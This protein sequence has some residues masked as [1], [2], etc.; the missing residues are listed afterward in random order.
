VV[1]GLFA[2]SEKRI[3][4]N[5]DTALLQDLGLTAQQIAQM[6][7]DLAQLRPMVRMSEYIDVGERLTSLDM[8]SIFARESLSSLWKLTDE[9]EPA[10]KRPPIVKS[11]MIDWDLVLRE[12]N[13][14]YNRIV[15]AFELLTRSERV[16]AVEAIEKDLKRL[17]AERRGSFL[18]DMWEN[19][20]LGFSR[21]LSITINGSMLPAITAI[22]D[23]EDRETMRFGLTRLAFAL[24]ECRADH[25]VYPGKLDDLV[26]KYVSTVPRDLFNDGELHYARKGAGYE[27]YSVGVNGKDD[28]G[29][30]D[31]SQTQDDLMICI[32]AAKK[33]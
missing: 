13:E 7:R 32:P 12:S 6:R 15:H 5:G 4:C 9:H 8:I 24:A 20:K 27:L 14:W 33:P 23:I 3:T 10:T 26:P 2:V 25:G 21:F 11:E 19:P 22:H 17:I 16:K 31:E 30:E 29:S 1:E 18:V 28:G